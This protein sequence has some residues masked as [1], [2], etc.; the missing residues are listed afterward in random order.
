M[1]LPHEIKIGVP[2]MRISV[3]DTLKRL[4]IN[5]EHADPA[6]IFRHAC[7]EAVDHW[8][9]T[10]EDHRLRCA[11]GVLLLIL[12]KH[13]RYEEQRLIEAELRALASL[14]AA[15]RGVPVDFSQVLDEDEG[16]KWVGLLRIWQEV[17]RD[18]GKN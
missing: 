12:I 8:M 1:E 13:E 11:I 6:V 5:T 14:D 4:E 9:I 17:R 18:A 3:E 10:S 15:T 2:I 16:R 7:E